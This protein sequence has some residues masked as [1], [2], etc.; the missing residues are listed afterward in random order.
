M[1]RLSDS[2]LLARRRELIEKGRRA[3][4]SAADSVS[5]LMRQQQPRY[6]NEIE[7]DKMI[8]MANS[9]KPQ[10]WKPP[11]L[12]GTC[13]TQ[14]QPGTVTNISLDYI[15]RQNQM[16]AKVKAISGRGTEDT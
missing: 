9:W 5:S 2:E 13:G 4:I 6:P 12:S 3:G 15:A 7:F 8:E 1:K 11:G 16:D 14:G 10:S